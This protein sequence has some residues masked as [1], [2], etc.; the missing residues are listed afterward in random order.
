MLPRGGRG[1]SEQTHVHTCRREHTHKHNRTR[2]RRRYKRRLGLQGAAGVS[3]RPPIIQVVINIKAK[4]QYGELVLQ[5]GPQESRRIL[6]SP[7]SHLQTPA[8]QSLTSLP[9]ILPT[10]LGISN[11][12]DLEASLNFPRIPLKAG[13]RR[14]E[15]VGIGW[16]RAACR[17]LGWIYGSEELQGSCA[18]HE[19][20]RW[21]TRNAKR[22]KSYSRLTFGVTS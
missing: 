18:E 22:R 11:K 3:N 6:L 5:P 21:H 7:V 8:W 14:K 1:A 17:C 13:G 16:E 9:C 10:S 12:I 2:L 19:Q 15:S 4:T 20:N